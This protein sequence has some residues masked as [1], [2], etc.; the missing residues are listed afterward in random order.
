MSEKMVCHDDSLTGCLLEI[1][2]RTA[3]PVSREALLAG[4]PM[5]GNAISV[6]LFVRA[7]DR[8]GLDAEVV[9]IAPENLT[10]ERLPLVMLLES[11]ACLLLNGSSD[12]GACWL[13]GENGQGKETSLQKILQSYS[14]G[15]IRVRRRYQFDDG[16]AQQTNPRPTAWF[17]QTFTQL[18]PIYSEVFAA[19]ILVNLFALVSPLFVMNV[20]DRVVPN[21][22]LETLWVLAIGVIIVFAFDFIVRSLRGYFMDVAGRRAD[23]RLSSLLFEKVMGMR[24][25][26]HPDSV[27]AF[28]NNLHEFEALRDFFASATL[29]T[30]I[31]LPFVLVILVVI[32]LIGGN[33]AWVP[34]AMIPIVLAIGILVQIPLRK[35]VEAG[36][37]AGAQKHA[38][39]IESLAGMEAVKALSAQ[40]ELQR[41]WESHVEMVSLCGLRSRQ[42]SAATVNLALFFQQISVVGVVVVGVYAIGA[43]ELTTGGLIACTLLA[44]RALSPLAQVASLLTR[45]QQSVAALRSLTRIVHLPDERPLEQHYLHRP[46]LSGGVEFRNVAFSYPEQRVQTLRDFSLSIAAG[47][48]VGIIGRVGSGKTTLLKMVLGLYLPDDGQVLIDGADMR[49]IDPVDLRRNIGYVSQEIVLFRGSLRE[50]ITFGLRICTDADVLRAARLAG[51]DEFASM[52]PDGYDMRIGEGGKGLSGGQRQAVALA[53]A[54]IADPQ[55]LVLDEPTSSMDNR[56]EEILRTQLAGIVKGKTVLLSTHRASMLSLV[57]KIAVAEGGRVA[58]FGPRDQIL[59][60]LAQHKLHA[61][62]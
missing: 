53:R 59:A 29:S 47:E 42:L 30:L 20:Y 11:G 19:S 50:N 22:A 10:L 1:C 55:I 12:G 46:K 38:T 60:A 54:L 61:V 39:L 15:A 6:D 24:L 31:D 28:A 7:A 17:W 27:G 51:V 45:Y 13:P 37:R 21:Q 4:L 9:Q 52:H 23:L 44:G 35:S 49:Q 34:F 33:V 62:S 3:V 48:R 57:D 25:G 26:S 43:G 18:W 40:G 14:G 41:R 32:G 56:S 8:Q 2:R 5:A 58:A 36:F 16:I